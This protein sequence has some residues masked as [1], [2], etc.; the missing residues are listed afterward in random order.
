MP[1]DDLMRLLRSACNDTPYVN[2]LKS[3]TIDAGYWTQDASKEL[4]IE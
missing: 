1:D 2:L 3:L 4:G